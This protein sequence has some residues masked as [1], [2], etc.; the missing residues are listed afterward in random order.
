MASEVVHSDRCENC[1]PLV[2]L[3]D[4]SSIP[5]QECPC[6]APLAM[7]GD[8]CMMCRL[9]TDRAAKEP[10]DTEPPFDDDG[11]DDE[12]GEG[13]PEGWPPA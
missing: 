13:E 4:A 1:D 5:G 6:L 8:A 2:N 3:L 9:E 10:P 11:D 12:I 7:L